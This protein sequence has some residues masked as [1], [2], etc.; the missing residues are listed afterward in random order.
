M[1]IQPNLFKNQSLSANSKVFVCGPGYGSNQIDLRNLARKSLESIKKVKVVYGEE[2]EAE[3]SYK[4]QSTDLQTLEA[5][6]AH[7]VD[8]TL[9]I[10]ESP[11]SLAELG[12]FTQ[13]PEIR[14]RLFVLVSSVFYR[15]ESYVARGP[16]SLLSRNNPNSVIYYEPQN[17]AEMLSRVL[18]P[19][20]FYKYAH[21]ILGNDYLYQTRISYGKKSKSAPYEDY[22][23]DVKS[24]YEKAIT[25]ISMIVGDRPNYSELLLLT[26]LAPNQLR[27]S[28]HGL[29]V[30]KK[31]EAVSS[32]R[33]HAV[34]GYSDSL[35]EPFSTTAISLARAKILAVA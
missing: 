13:L 7:D 17:K 22:I 35:L 31:I 25:L 29:F 24:T 3:Y 10:L 9:L 5:R 23:K 32:G 33:Y 6:F 18:F 26:G 27:A 28:L 20:T 15:A 2:I 21:H 8:F 1:L 19:L 16:L 34:N 4:K 30:D 11:G 14:G 12:T